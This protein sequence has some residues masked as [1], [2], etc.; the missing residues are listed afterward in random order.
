MPEPKGDAKSSGTENAATNSRPGTGDSTANLSTS[1]RVP[2]EGV[3]LLRTANGDVVEK[4][5]ATPDATIPAP[6]SPLSADDER[7]LARIRKD[8]ANRFMVAVT[9]VDF[10]L[11]IL[12]RLSR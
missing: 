3:I 4:M 10:L 6:S 9:D 1:S 5:V 2:M 11:E 7:R 12:E 8:R